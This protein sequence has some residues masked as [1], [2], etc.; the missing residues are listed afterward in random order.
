MRL[1]VLVNEP[2]FAD[3]IAP[4]WEALPREHRGWWLVV[5][6]TMAAYV[7]T[8]GY[9]AAY[10]DRGG[11][12]P[13]L[14]ASISDLNKSRQA[15]RDAVAYMEHG[16]GQSYG[17]DPR[18]AH[19][20]SYA[21]GRGR[22]HCALIMAPNAM[23]AA[24][25]SA[26]YPS[27]PVHVIGATRVLPPPRATEPLLVVSFHWNGAMPEMRNAFTHYHRHLA[28]LAKEL[29]V[30]GHAHPRMRG[31][32]R[33][34]YRAAGIRHEWDLCRVAERAT[35][36]AVDNSSTLYELGRTRPVIAMNQPAYR[37][38]VEHGLRFW[39]HVPGPQVEDGDQLLATAKRLL[40]DGETTQEAAQR[41]SVMADVFPRLDG[42]QQASRILTR[43][44]TGRA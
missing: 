5:N 1:D 37:R 16:V 12:R 43:W 27:I 21:G 2:Q 25:W 13:V 3:H 24:R 33:A 23:A 10:L 15:G 18:T 26:A 34:R 11:D 32:L 8:L 17:G 7:E 19:H 42:A 14:V 36:Y 35:V 38:H 28:R 20:P 31:A 41:A 9:R 30:L 29:P 4:V 22:D 40:Y 39:S 44:L 6:R